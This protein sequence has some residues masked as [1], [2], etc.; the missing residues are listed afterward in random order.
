MVFGEPSRREL[1]EDLA[2]ARRDADFQRGLADGARSNAQQL[3]KERDDARIIGR[4]TDV[5]EHALKQAEKSGEVQISAAQTA[6]EVV[7]ARYVDHATAQHADEMITEHAD[8]IRMEKGPGWDGEIRDHL[9]EKFSSDGTYD[10]VKRD[11]EADAIRTVAETL[12][13]E[14]R[15]K[16]KDRLASPEEQ[17][18]LR[19]KAQKLM[20][21]SGDAS[22]IREAAQKEAEQ[23]AL[24]EAQRDIEQE[25]E[26]RK[27]EYVTGFKSD[28]R[29]GNQGQRYAQSVRSRLE[30]KW[31]GKAIEELEEEIQD[32]EFKRLREERVKRETEALKQEKFY[33]EQLAEFSK[34]GIETTKIPEGSSLTIYLG[35]IESF[36][37]RKQNERGNWHNTQGRRVA[38]KRILKVTAL[39]DGR[40]AVDHDSL[41]QSDSVYEQAAAIEHGMIIHLGRREIDKS[42][43]DESPRL[44]EVLRE[45]IVLYYDDDKTD[46]NITDTRLPIANIEI[47]GTSALVDIEEARL[48]S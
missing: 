28:W 41:E 33:A 7:K 16:E 25:E 19:I 37:T 3:E 42:N 2:V 32:E 11:T 31:N 44:N 20:E 22:R 23:I 36:D 15:Q 45:G 8:A 47:N 43:G 18:R 10:R 29:E 14:I 27:P 35:E 40:F 13:E 1:E 6:E 24:E 9:D 4:I 12:R 38:A 46:E 5:A 39:N 26:A 21:E 34:G 48:A 17:E 30:S